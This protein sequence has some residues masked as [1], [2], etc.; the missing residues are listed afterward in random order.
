MGLR[1]LGKQINAARVKP[2]GFVEVR[3]ALVPPPLPPRGVGQQFRNAAAIRQELACLLIVMLGT[4]VI[5]LTGV[6]I[7]PFGQYRL[8]EVRLK[9]KRSFGRPPCLLTEG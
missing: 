9:S 2:L 1:V 3:L 7:I 6:M 8:A 5:L 4:F